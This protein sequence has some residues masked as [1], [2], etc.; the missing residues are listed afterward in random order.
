MYYIGKIDKEIYKCVT[1]DIQTD[2]VIIT[3]KQIEHIKEHH[4]NDYEKYFGYVLQTVRYPD[5]IIEANKPD[6]A[7]V[8][9]HIDDNGKNY[10]LILRLKTSA[11]PKEYKNSVITFFKIDDRKWNQYLHTKKILYARNH[12]LDKSE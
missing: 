11:D 1:E 3:D 10:K 2:T 7:V 8:L 6:T 4:P 12:L 9:K 5:Y